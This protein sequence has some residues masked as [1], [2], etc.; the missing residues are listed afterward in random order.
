MGK[1]VIMNLHKLLDERNM[2]MRKLS[3]LSGVR[4]AALHALANQQRQNIHFRHIERIAE[5]LKLNDINELIT[6]IDTDDHDDDVDD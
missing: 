5:A 3:L 2:S 1:K 6:W 4:L